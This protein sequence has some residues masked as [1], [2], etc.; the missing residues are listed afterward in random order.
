MKKKKSPI[1]I[2]QLGK[3]RPEKGLRS[4][5]SRIVTQALK[6]LPQENFNG[7]QVTNHFLHNHWQTPHGS[8]HLVNHF[9]CIAQQPYFTLLK[10]SVH[11]LAFEATMMSNLR[12][13][14]LNQPE[15]ITCFLNPSLQDQCKVPS[16]KGFILTKSVE[17]YS[18]CLW[19][20]N[21]NV[22]AITI[23]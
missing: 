9:T 11:L 2:F 7:F 23:S 12:D 16:L 4:R 10:S 3:V 18:F 21:R 13:F 1:L 8:P 20:W 14:Q 5:K 6:N 22:L 17:T 15:T 19:S